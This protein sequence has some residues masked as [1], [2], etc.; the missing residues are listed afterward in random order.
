MFFAKI[1]AHSLVSS[2]AFAWTFPFITKNAVSFQ[3][4]RHLPLI[5]GIS[6]RIQNAKWIVQYL[7]SLLIY[8][9]FCFFFQICCRK[10]YITISQNKDLTDLETCR[11]FPQKR[12]SKK[13]TD[14]ELP[15]HLAN[16]IFLL[17]SL[18]NLD[19]WKKR[20]FAWMNCLKCNN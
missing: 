4:K 5:D 15:L 17:M 9:G 3:F 7:H 16:F 14:H 8:S 2:L 10:I 20:A 13:S 18:K 12:K 6:L 19:T 11:N 1:C